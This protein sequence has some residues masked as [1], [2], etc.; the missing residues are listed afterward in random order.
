[1]D[2]RNKVRGKPQQAIHHT[3]V[4]SIENSADMTPEELLQEIR[5]KIHEILKK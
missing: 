4:F 5:D 1:M 2:N 3:N